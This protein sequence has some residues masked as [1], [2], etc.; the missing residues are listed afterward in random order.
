M[1]LDNLLEIIIEG[2]QKPMVLWWN[3][4]DK[5]IKLKLSKKI[6]KVSDKIDK[7]T[8]VY[9][10]T[11]KLSE[12]LFEDVPNS[13]EFAKQLT[14]MADVFVQEEHK[15][16]TNTRVKIQQYIQLSRKMYTIEQLYQ[17]HKMFMNKISQT[18]SKEKQY[19]YD[20][21]LFTNEGMQYCLEYYLA[22]YKKIQD[23][24]LIEQKRKYIESQNINFGFGQLPGLW[25]DFHQDEVL[26][27]F[28][29]SILNN[30][31]RNELL[32][33]Y[34]ITKNIVMSIHLN[35]DKQGSCSAEYTKYDLN[36]VV[37]SF[38]ILIITMIDT[39]QS[40]NITNLSSLYFKPYGK[41]PSLKKIKSLL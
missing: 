39:F 34:Y 3:E 12:L 14:Y 33:Q 18:L 15:I 40:L 2:A 13:L 24:N 10:N 16:N 6:Q 4:I 11:I 20:I 5:D 17:H 26:T 28:I 38:K 31:I 35:C 9:N 30:K 36:S 1:I 8:N 23:A 29:Y 27:K 19:E 41:K 21:K 22:V 32:V 37:H 25:H 7:N